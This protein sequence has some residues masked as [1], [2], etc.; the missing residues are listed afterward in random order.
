[1]EFDE[2]LSVEEDDITISAAPAFVERTATQNLFGYY[3]CVEN[4]SSKK[5]RLV[6]KNWNIT[7]EKGNL[8]N[9]SEEGFKGEVP[10]LEPGEC[11]EFTSI[12]PLKAESA[13]F[14]GTF[15]VDKGSE[16][17]NLKVPTFSFGGRKTNVTLN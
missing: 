3:F 5:I 14:Y 8:F 16:I 13:V 7:D 17:K 15:A 10:E 1:M 11:F 6:G 4:H 2:F 9:D 12:A